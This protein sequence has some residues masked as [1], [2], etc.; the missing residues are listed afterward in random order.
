MSSFTFGPSRTFTA[1]ADLPIHRR[2]KLSSGS[3]VLAGATEDYFGITET[4]VVSG[5]P[6]S[7]RL[8]NCGGTSFMTALTSFAAGAVVYGVADGKV[9]DVS[10][11]NVIAGTALQAASGNNSIVE[12]LLP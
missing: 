2:V 12:V 1:G 9:D 8:K 6:V 11:D 3:V 4:P 5:R 7:V 10:T